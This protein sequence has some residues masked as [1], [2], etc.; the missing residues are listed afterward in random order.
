MPSKS[1]KKIKGQVRKAKAAAASMTNDVSEQRV[2][3][4]RRSTISAI[5]TTSC[6]HGREEF[7]LVCKQFTATFYLS[8]SYM[9]NMEFR[10]VNIALKAA[11][12]KF[13][14]AV[15]S[16]T[17]REM[18]KKNFI[19]NGVNSL[20][21]TMKH[22]I[23]K[24]LN[25]SFGSAEALMYIDSYSPSS[26]VPHGTIDRRDAKHFLRNMDVSNGCKRS[27]IKYFMKQ[28]PCNC[29]DELYS[30]VKSITPKMTVCPGCKQRKEKERV[31][32]YV[33]VVS[34]CNTAARHV[35]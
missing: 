31:C 21:G 34:V 2:G 6:D 22:S 20:L 1:R 3:I 4:N 26:P 28:I 35:N 16:N 8:Y 25:I 14:E 15:N 9:V 19:C 24:D 27:L 13:P 18:L 29:L 7:E 23:G 30:Q 32:L 11:Y 10:Q 5:T 12:D 17:N 33:R